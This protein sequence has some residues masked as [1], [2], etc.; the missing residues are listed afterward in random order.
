MY[1]NWFSTWTPPA[2]FGF[3][4]AASPWWRKRQER[5]IIMV[6]LNALGN[7][8]VTA[9]ASQ[10]RIDH[11]R[12][13][14]DA[15]C[16]QICHTHT[17]ST[18]SRRNHF[19]KWSPWTA[20][21]SNWYSLF[22]FCRY[23]RPRQFPCELFCVEINACNCCYGRRNNNGPAPR[24]WSGKFTRVGSRVFNTSTVERCAVQRALVP[25]SQMVTKWKFTFI[26][27]CTAC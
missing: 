26:R 6:N 20:I 1:R 17:S 14:P 21:T 18:L 24:M 8:E 27:C 13:R 16:I 5:S 2:A 23:V 3:R 12:Y 10:L 11:I 4:T 25:L 7:V 9:G 22:P 19:S 15:H